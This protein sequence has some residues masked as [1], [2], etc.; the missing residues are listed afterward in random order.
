MDIKLNAPV[1]CQDG[2]HGGHVTGV[3][4]NPETDELIHLVV[5]TDGVERMVPVALI[6]DAG[7]EAVRLSCTLVSLQ[8]QQLLVET[9]YVREM[10]DQYEFYPWG[11]T[12]SRLVPTTFAVK[13][14]DIPDGDLE[15][16]RGM[17]VF[18]KDGRVGRVDD[19]VVDPI[20]D[21]ITH[22]VLREGHLWGAK[23]IVVG[24]EH[25]KSIEDDGVY[26]KSTKAQ[27]PR[28]QSSPVT[29]KPVDNPAG[30]SLDIPIHAPVHCTD[31]DFGSTTCLIINPV[32]D[33]ITHL[34]V[35]ENGL[36]GVDHMVPVSFVTGTAADGITV[37]CD[38]ATLARQPDFVKYEYDW[39]DKEAPDGEEH[40]YWPV[41]LPDATF[42]Y[43]APR[44][45]LL[46]QEQI[47]VGELAVRRGMA[48]Y[49]AT[50]PEGGETTGRTH[51]G[52]VAAFLADPKTAHITHLILREGHLWGQRDVT[53]PV[54]A[55]EKIE[56]GDV[57]L[58]LTKSA[59]EAL[60]AV[61]VKHW[62]PFGD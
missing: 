9:R 15:I 38:R 2:K 58:K 36:L 18:A 8:A 50:E 17:A 52:Q 10:V 19:V 57:R 59:V 28:L 43:T 31:G 32:D 46:E 48:V 49:A 12:E 11:E 61:P 3:I 13:D 42:P 7:P 1:E 16:K 56:E 14:E 27:V 45:L 26:L 25:I 51:I 44:Y 29:P 22:I 35:K 21:C 62:T 24:V 54:N 20:N 23:E 4:V 33:T 34:V 40:G 47:P 30:T 41:V 55:I 5:K 37:N 39:F 60:P 6:R 53:I